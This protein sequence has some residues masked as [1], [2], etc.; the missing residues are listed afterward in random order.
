MFVKRGIIIIF[1]MLLTTACQSHAADPNTE[2]KAASASAWNGATTSPSDSV[3]ASTDAFEE[4]TSAA[5]NDDSVTIKDIS[6]WDHPVKQVLE[7]RRVTI[8]SVVLKNNRTYP[9]FEVSL[10]FDA[11]DEEGRNLQSLLSD[12]AKA[13]AFWDFR[14]IDNERKMNISVVCNR[15]KKTIDSMILNGKPWQPDA[16]LSGQETADPIDLYLNEANIDK[17]QLNMQAKGD[18]DGDG[19][20]EE[21]ILFRDHY[22]VIKQN[23]NKYVNLGM[24]EDPLEGIEHTN[25]AVTVQSLDKTTAKYVIVY[26]ENSGYAKGFTIYQLHKGKVEVLLN[27]YPDATN[28]GERLLEDIDND[29]VFDSVSVFNYGD[30]QMHV[31][32]EYSPFN[33]SNVQ[34]TRVEYDNEE[35]RFVYPGKP[36]EV[37]LNLIEDMNDRAAFYDEIK[38]LATTKQAQ[39]YAVEVKFYTRSPY[40]TASSLL[41]ELFKD[42]NLRKVVRVEGSSSDEG[43][44]FF[45][46]KRTGERWTVTEISDKAPK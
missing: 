2:K 4:S 32:T 42:E 34:A 11:E 18:L 5:E 19:I 27:N 8:N 6:K 31:V 12:T 29:G 41:F 36:E 28:E 22:Y 23:K 25:T 7:G 40:F 13:N 1:A 46:L 45:T 16:W 43:E 9:I 38:Q 39:Q 10:P 33:L 21:I 15:M 17:V 35:G 14:L 44:L 26:A 3:P 37:V 30:Y 20:D 24:L